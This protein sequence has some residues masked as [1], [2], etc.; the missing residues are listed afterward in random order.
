MRSALTV[1]RESRRRIGVLCST[2]VFAAVLT[3]C[4]TTSTRW[5]KPGSNEESVAFDTN[6]CEF[7][8][9]AVSMAESAQS[10]DTY[11]TVNSQGQIV[12]T[13]MPGADSLRFMRQ[14]DAFDRCMKS[15]GYRSVA[16]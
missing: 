9:Q 13:Q 4:V 1:T 15:R 2:V 14:S 6:E 10:N 12:S 16:N 11:V 8:A 3:A 7:Y 5:D